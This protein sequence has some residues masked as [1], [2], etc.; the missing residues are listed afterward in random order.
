MNYSYSA[1][2]VEDPYLASGF[3]ALQLAIERTFVEMWTDLALPRIAD[4]VN[5]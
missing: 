1:F 3:M 5:Y 2:T 4:D